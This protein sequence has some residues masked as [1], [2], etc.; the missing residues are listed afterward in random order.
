MS[1]RRTFAAAAAVLGLAGAA[2]TPCASADPEPTLG[3]VWGTNQRGYGT[4]RPATIDGGGSS[5]GLV[6]N[7]SWSSWGGPQATGTGTA[8]WVPPGAPNAAGVRQPANIVAYNLGTCNG[9]PAYQA[10]KW[11][12]PGKGE[13]FN[14]SGGQNICTGR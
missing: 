4:V 12:F 6:E 13:S 11:Y 14:P 10:V 7:I 3:Q 2:A 9:K 5:T 1:I 8:L